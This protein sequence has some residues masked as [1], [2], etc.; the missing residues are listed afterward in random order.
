M[1][2]KRIDG[3]I[4]EAKRL[5]YSRRQVMRRAVA[6]GLSVPAVTAALNTSG[7]AAPGSDMVASRASSSGV[8]SAGMSANSGVDR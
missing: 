5:K 6:L 2:D 8:I 4:S 1:T 3:L 7:Y